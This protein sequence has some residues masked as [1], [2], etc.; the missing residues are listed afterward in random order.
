MLHHDLYD[1][2]G[3]AESEVDRRRDADARGDGCHGVL[4]RGSDLETRLHLTEHRAPGTVPFTLLP[5]VLHVR[6]GSVDGDGHRG[7]RDLDAE[8]LPARAVGEAYLPAMRLH[9][10]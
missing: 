3:D 7:H 2:Q 5:E 9:L 1:L 6:S 4:P 8:S 10:R